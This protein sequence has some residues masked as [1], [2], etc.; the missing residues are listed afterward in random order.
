MRI[1]LH[2][3][4]YNVDAMRNALRLFDC[5]FDSFQN[6]CLRVLNC[7]EGDVTTHYETKRLK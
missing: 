6:C 5:S 3:R 4:H 1:L 7:L 2:D